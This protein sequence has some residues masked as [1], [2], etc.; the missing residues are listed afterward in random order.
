MNRLQV[1]GRE[2]LRRILFDNT[3]VSGWRAAA[4]SA[5]LVSLLA[6]LAAVIRPV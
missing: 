4:V 1:A 6:I 2:L 3:G 5:A